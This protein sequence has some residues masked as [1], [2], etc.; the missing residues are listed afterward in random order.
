MSLLDQVRKLEQEVVERLKELEPLKH[1][2]EQLRK[3]AGR[4]GV[5]YSP[6][7]ADSDAK[8]STAARRGGSRASG[9][10]QT[11]RS[12]AKSTAARSRAPARSAKTA[13]KPRGARSAT[14]KTAAKSTQAGDTAS[15]AKATTASARKR[16]G[17]GRTQSGARR[18]P[19]ARPGQRSDDVMRL[20]SE[21]PGI[22]VREIG[23][24]LGVDATGLYRVAKRL[25]D[26]GQVRKDGTRL[27]PAEPAT[28]SAAASEAAAAGA[29]RTT[30]GNGPQPPKA[31]AD[32]EPESPTATADTASTSDT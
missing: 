27:Y 21:N 23:E 25:T 2:Y 7:S 1:E 11:G 19:A 22:T 12:A 6:R 4:L 5:N 14:R 16:T 18:A 32:A 17:G 13:A 28:V 3:L 9:R 30:P 15:S 20:V 31:T 24:R 8:A 29:A 26:E 10:Q